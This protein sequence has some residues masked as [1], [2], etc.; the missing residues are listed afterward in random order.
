V[1]GVASFRRGPE[2]VGTSFMTGSDKGPVFKNFQAKKKAILI[3]KQTLITFSYWF[4]LSRGE[5]Y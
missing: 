4:K 5:C 1:R 3:Y 2:S